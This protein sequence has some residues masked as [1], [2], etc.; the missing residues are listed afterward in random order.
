M[1]AVVHPDAG[2]LKASYWARRGYNVVSFDNAGSAHRGVDF[3][4]ILKY[5]LGKPE[6]ED[7]VDGLRF[8]ASGG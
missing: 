8:L 4:G 1:L 3:E 2:D 7:Q 5:S 6:V